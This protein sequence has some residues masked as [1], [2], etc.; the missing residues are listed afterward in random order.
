MSVSNY[1]AKF[2]QLSK[3]KLELIFIEAKR[4]SHF[5]KDLRVDIYDR[6]TMFRPATYTKVLDSA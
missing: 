1:V 2:V 6:V 3:F 4:V 5:L